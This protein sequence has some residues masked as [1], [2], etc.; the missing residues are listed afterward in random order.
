MRVVWLGLW[1][2]TAAGAA[3]VLLTDCE[4]PAGWRVTGAASC[5]AADSAAVGKGAI[6]VGL[7]GNAILEL[8]KQWLPGSAA[9]DTYQGVSFYVKGDGSDN[10]G[11]LAI[12]AAAEGAY[13]FVHYF[14]LRETAWHKLTVPWAEFVPEGQWDPIGSPGALPPSG[15]TTI[16]CGSRWVIGHNNQPL[17][18][19]EFSLDQVMLEEQVAAPAAAPPPRPFASVVERLKA[20]QPVSIVCLGDSITA[21][22]SLPD[23]EQQRYAVG[24]GQR[25]RTWLGYEQV[26]CV[27][28]A[29]GG[30]KLTDARAWIPRDLAGDPPDLVTILY[31][32][33]DKSNTFTR[34]AFKRS[35]VDYLDRVAR[36]TGGRSA[37]LPMA[38]L[39]GNGPRFVMMDDFAEVVREVARERD[40]PCLDLHA[41][42]K[43]IGRERI[44]EFFADMAHPNIEGHQLLAEAI[45]GYLARA[46]GVTPPP[47][48]PAPAIEPGV[49][50]SWS[51]EADAEGWR[52]D[53]EV[54]VAQGTAVSGQGALRFA[55]AAPAADHRRAWSPIV[56]VKPGQRYDLSARIYRTEPA[57]GNHGLYVGYYT[58]A[59]GA[60]EPGIQPVRGAS[61]M[62]GVWEP[63]SGR[64]TIPDGVAALTVLIWAAREASG[65]FWVDE[66]TLTPAPVVARPSAVPGG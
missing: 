46:A 51:F 11:C 41:V 39:P 8:G 57:K 54:S 9:W 32:Y 29:V 7:P 12:G 14:P 48:P 22:T 26:T 35:L 53:G 4:T 42:F 36:A 27:S 6:R 47:P 24:V 64:I 58:T 63:V 28:R 17:P 23:K 33:N 25:L 3:P 62:P 59:D 21:G 19:V 52:L 38:T 65:T 20:R 61:N 66:V 15:I 10:Y 43:A 56:P 34:E 13:T 1:L 2:A 55:M 18:R 16:R 49:A 50:R 40:L 44:G 30:A 60:G 31:G 37:L 5:A 45:A